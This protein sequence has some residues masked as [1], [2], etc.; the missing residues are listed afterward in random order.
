MRTITVLYDQSNTEL[1][2]VLFSQLNTNPANTWNSFFDTDS[3][4]GTYDQFTV[5][6]TD[7]PEAIGVIDAL[8]LAGK[9]LGYR[10]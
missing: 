9:L 1:V 3:I 10:V 2:R 4:G 6:E 8:Y 5:I 7:K